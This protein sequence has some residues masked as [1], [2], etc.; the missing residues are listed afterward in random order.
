M[1]IVLVWIHYVIVQGCSLSY[2]SANLLPD[3]PP[4][5]L[6]S[7]DYC[8]DYMWHW[9]HG[10]SYQRKS[11]ANPNKNVLHC[12]FFFLQVFVSCDKVQ[13]V[14]YNL[15]TS[16]QIFV[17]VCGLVH[18]CI[19]QTSKLDACFVHQRYSMYCLVQH[20]WHMPLL[21]HSVL[22]F[23]FIFSFCS[24]KHNKQLSSSYCYLLSEVIFCMHMYLTCLQL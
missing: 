2:F 16:R 3:C 13:Y 18:W 17:H 23:L 11:K 12:L 21:T 22:S 5:G 15:V 8:K 1:Q 4:T 24:V 6:R 10:L 9:P 20:V 7:V 19:H 14:P